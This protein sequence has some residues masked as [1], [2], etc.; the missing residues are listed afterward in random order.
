MPE[1]Y[2]IEIDDRAVLVV[3]RQYDSAGQEVVISNISVPDRAAELLRAP[4]QSEQ[5]CP[6]CN[7]MGRVPETAYQYV[8]CNAC[9]GKGIST[10]SDGG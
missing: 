4:V 9:N 6:D 1:K 5:K 3:V 2:E 10:R 7:G 8:E